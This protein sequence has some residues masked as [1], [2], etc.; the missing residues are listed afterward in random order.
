[1]ISGQI[2]DACDK[3]GGA[4]IFI[5]E[6]DSLVGSRENQSMH[7]ATRRILSVILQRVEGFQGKGNNVLIGATNRKEDL[8][9]ALISRFDTSVRYNLPDFETRQSILRRY[10]KHLGRVALYN[11]AKESEGFSSRDIKD[12]CE[13]AERRWAAQAISQNRTED[14]E[15]GLPV[16]ADY[17]ES[18]R[19]KKQSVGNKEIT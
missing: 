13:Q 2:F 3:L 9:P 11:L 5:D 6:I 18:L 19:I 14:M 15:K 17:E 7:E 8:D 1:M 10:A 4:I 12:M 16:L